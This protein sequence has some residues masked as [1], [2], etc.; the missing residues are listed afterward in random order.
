M[1]TNLKYQDVLD[2]VLSRTTD[3]KIDVELEK[4]FIDE[5][6]RRFD[7][8]LSKEI[9]D[10]SYLIEKLVSMVKSYVAISHESVLGGLLCG[11]VI[12]KLITTY[13]KEDPERSAKMFMCLEDALVEDLKTP[14][15]CVDEDED[16]DED[17]DKPVENSALV[18]VIK[19][20]SLEDALDQIRK[21][22]EEDIK[23]EKDKTKKVSKKDK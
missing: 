1:L 16:E 23:K 7:R 12:S 19:A 18:K 8:A 4:R 11:A 13:T 10:E 15:I 5:D 3:G 2:C 17:E 20:S 9:V 21:E 22:I 14:V 6:F